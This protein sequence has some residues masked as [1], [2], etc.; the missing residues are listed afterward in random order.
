MTAVL[1]DEKTLIAELHD[2]IRYIYNPKLAEEMIETF[3]G[4]LKSKKNQEDRLGVIQ[5]W[6]ELYKLEKYRRQ[7][8]RRRPSYSERT[9]ACAACGYPASHR[10]HLWDIATHGENE[11]TVNLCANCHELHHLIYN[12]LAKDSDYSRK[13]LLHMLD[14]NRIPYVAVERLLGWCLATMRYEIKN[15]WLEPY[16]VSAEWIETQLNWTEYQ[17]KAQ[18]LV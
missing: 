2:L 18:G 17:R 11:V 4:A 16:K 1:P 8:R 6:T 3:E 15:G 12:V 5:H 10:H 9:K 13:L 7:R 14:S